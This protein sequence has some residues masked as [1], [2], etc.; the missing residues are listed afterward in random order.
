ML[1]LLLLLLTAVVAVVV[2]VAAEA[3]SGGAGGL[4][5]TVDRVRSMTWTKMNFELLFQLIMIFNV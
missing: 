1:L 2:V 3:W 5:E 4:I